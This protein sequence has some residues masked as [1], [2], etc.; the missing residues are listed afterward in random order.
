MRAL[1]GQPVPDYQEPTL[2]GALL[3]RLWPGGR[4]SVAEGAPVVKQTYLVQRPGRPQIVGALRVETNLLEHERQR[5]RGPV[6]R[7]AVRQLQRMAQHGQLIGAER[8]SPFG[9]SDG[10]IV[11]DRER[12]IRYAS[13]VAINLYRRIGNPAGLVGHSLSQLGTVD[14]DLARTALSQCICVEQ[15]EETDG[16]YWIKKAIPLLALPRPIWARWLRPGE[17]ADPPNAVLL[18]VCDTTTSR[19]QEQA[20]RV[21]TALIQEVHHRV[22]NNLQ[23]IAALLRVQARRVRYKESRLAIEDAV[24]RILSVAVIHEFLSGQDSRVINIKDVSNR[25][26]TQLRDGTLG[27]DKRIDIQLDGPPIYLPAR[28]ATACALVINELLQNA[29]EH[30]FKE[31]QEGQ[32]NLTFQDE[33]DRVVVRVRDNGTGLPADFNIQTAESL[34]LQIVQTLVQEDLKGT[35]EIHNGDG[36]EAI[37]A[38]PKSILGGE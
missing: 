31:R 3:N 32:V 30:G 36:A 35:I 38:F 7:Q 2:A 19:R 27:P 4:S 5:R 21:K 11:T 18:I 22:K 28:Q 20:L 16:R 23:T 14:N 29:V 12:V 34:G 6:F 13:G 15:E 33:A 25:I 37:V 24:S 17:A 8:L 26:V 1:V 9:E 10:L